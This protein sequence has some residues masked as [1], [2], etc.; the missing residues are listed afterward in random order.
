[1][2]G[3]S[4]RRPEPGR[5]LLVLGISDVIVL[6]AEPIVPVTL[7]HVS[8]WGKWV[9][10]VAI[11]DDAADRIASLAER[12]QI[13]WASEWGHNAHTAF[14]EVLG[15]PERPWPFLPVQFDKLPMIRRYADGVPW[16]WVDDPL[17]DLA[18]PQPEVGD[19]VVLRVRLGEGLSGVDADTLLDRVTAVGAA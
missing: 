9:R 15:L 12:F 7:H 5:P 4:A 18:A 19:G 6:E 1:M 13:V 10:D 3:Y 16:A 17:V 11:A 14:R 8:A 2:G